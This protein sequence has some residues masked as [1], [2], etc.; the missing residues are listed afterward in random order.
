MYIKKI[1]EKVPGKWES[2]YFRVK[3]PKASRAFRHALD[4][5]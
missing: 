4:P 2:A 3:N 1:E 5:S